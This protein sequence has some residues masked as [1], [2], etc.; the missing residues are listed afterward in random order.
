MC[1]WSK[2][3]KHEII[4]GIESQLDILKEKVYIKKIEVLSQCSLTREP[5]CYHCF[6]LFLFT[7]IAK[8]LND[9]CVFPLLH[10]TSVCEIYFLTLVHV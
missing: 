9:F 1:F 10:F 2:E 3:R 8:L 4:H 7:P 5:L 6:M